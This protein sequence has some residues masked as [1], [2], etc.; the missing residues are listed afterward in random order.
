[1]RSLTAS[2]NRRC[3]ERRAV[4]LELLFPFYGR[5]FCRV[6]CVAFCILQ[7]DESEMTTRANIKGWSEQSLYVSVD[8]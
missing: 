4:N 5:S 6:G 1:M 3:H 8:R 2:G 7:E